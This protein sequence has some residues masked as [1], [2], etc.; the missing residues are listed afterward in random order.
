MTAPLPLGDFL[1]VAEVAEFCQVST[2]TVYRLCAEEG[3]PRT[4]VGKSIRIPAAG[5]DEWLRDW[6]ARP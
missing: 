5:L 3:M 6:Q 4:R 1:T 2:A